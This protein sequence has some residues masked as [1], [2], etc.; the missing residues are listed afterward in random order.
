MLERLKI[1]ERLFFKPTAERRR[2]SREDVVG[3][4]VEILGGVYP[5]EN[6]SARSFL[7]S[8]CGVERKVGERVDVA[9]SIPLGE[10]KL[11]FECLAG[12]IRVDREREQVAA[13]FL[14]LDDDTQAVIDEHFG[15]ASPPSW[16]RAA[17]E[18]LGLGNL[19]PHA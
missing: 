3:G 9:L 7:A 14:D 18:R 12:V 17:I 13:V 4:T 2:W 6:W 5:V 15:V 16:K 11:E 19:L 1:L 10:E 8:P